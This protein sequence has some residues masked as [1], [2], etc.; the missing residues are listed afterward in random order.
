MLTLRARRQ[1]AV[2][3][4]AALILAVWTV[5]HMSS[6][7]AASPRAL[8]NADTVSGGSSSAEAK[9]ATAL[10]FSVD[11]VGGPTWD[12]MTQAQFAQYQVLIAGDPNCGQIAASLIANES[13]WAPVVMGTAVN[14]KQGNRVLVGTDPVLHSGGSGPR[15]T[16]ISDGI[17]F[18]GAQPG[19]TGLYFDSSCGGNYYGQAGVAASMMGQLSSGS[20]SWTEDDSPPCASTGLSKQVA[21]S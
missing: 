5:M 1:T 12:A 14:T 15:T 16:V 8:I 6:A 19:R 13:T 7:F 18:A 10:G 9:F 4:V 3:L 11:V 2:V 20:G 21:Y 17:D